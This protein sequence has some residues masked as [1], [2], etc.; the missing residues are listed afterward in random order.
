MNT[1][2]FIEY[3]R[4]LERKKTADSRQ[5][6]VLNEIEKLCVTKI[7]PKKQGLDV[8]IEEGLKSRPKK[9]YQS[10]QFYNTLKL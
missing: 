5:L 9:S 2:W 8:V 7:E 3:G 10:Q 4:V 6:E 1:E